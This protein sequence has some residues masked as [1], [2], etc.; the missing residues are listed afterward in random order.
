MPKSVQRS[1]VVRS[2]ATAAAA[3]AITTVAAA[4]ASAWP[5]DH[6]RI[7]GPHVDFGS[8][9]NGAASEP[10]DGGRLYWDTTGG[11]VTPTLSGRLFMNN[12]DGLRGRLRI[13][14]YDAAQNRIT[15]RHSTWR[16]AAAGF[17]AFDFVDF[18]PFGASNVYGVEVSTQIEDAAGDIHTVGSVLETI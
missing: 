4:P 17:N 12:V 14:Y 11:V 5:V 7:P 15:L 13:D 6:P 8:N 16:T 18:A 10:N 1:T 3:L 2:L 9:W